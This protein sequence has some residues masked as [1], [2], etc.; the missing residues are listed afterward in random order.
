MTS[1]I[2]WASAT[3]LEPCTAHRMFSASKLLNGDLS[4]MKSNG[5]SN[6]SPEAERVGYHVS[7]NQANAR[8]PGL[9]P[10][11]LPGISLP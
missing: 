3:R 11:C 8:L 7:C 1:Q 6:P 10:H 4:F 9:A 5:S 2:A